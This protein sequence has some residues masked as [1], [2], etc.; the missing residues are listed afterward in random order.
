MQRSEL[1]S[2]TFDRFYDAS[3]GL[4]LPVTVLNFDWIIVGGVRARAIPLLGLGVVSHSWHSLLARLIAAAA[5]L[6][7]D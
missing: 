2:A 3:H 5:L 7:I 4:R 6:F 1:D